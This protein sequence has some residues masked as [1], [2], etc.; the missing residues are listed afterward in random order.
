[1]LYRAA[2]AIAYSE[3]RIT[4]SAG[5]KIYA[6]VDSVTVIVNRENCD[7]RPRQ[8][9]PFRTTETKEE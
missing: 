1:M 3:C 6:G 5:I 9:D 4:H 8:V 7:N 2:Y